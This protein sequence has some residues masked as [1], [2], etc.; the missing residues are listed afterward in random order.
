MVQC[1]NTTLCH[2]L[3]L[4]CHGTLSQHQ[5]MPCLLPLVPWYEYTVPTPVYAMCSLPLVLWYTVPTSIYTI[6]SLPLVLWYTVPTPVYAMCS[7][8]LVPWYTVPTPI[9][10]ICSLPLVPLITVPQLEQCSALIRNLWR[11]LCSFIAL[12]HR[13]NFSYL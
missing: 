8:P 13:C 1:P 11:F 3:Y 4:W 5:L 7:L 10:T 12:Y 6:C 9:Y 2:V